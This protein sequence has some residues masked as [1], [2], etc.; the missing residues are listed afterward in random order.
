MSSRRKSKNQPHRVRCTCQS[1]ECYLGSYLDAYG[2]TQSGVEVWPETKK[3][4]AL[5]DEL[6]RLSINSVTN[7]IATLSTSQTPLLTTPYD[8]HQS[9]SSPSSYHGP[10]TFPSAASGTSSEDDIPCMPA[11]VQKPSSAERFCSRAISAREDGVRVFQCDHLHN[12]TLRKMSP[13]LLLIT[14]VVV[15]LT[16]YGHL[17][18]SS[19]SWLLDCLGMI[20][21]FVLNYGVNPLHG[22]V[23]LASSDA[24]ALRRI[25]KTITTAMKWLNI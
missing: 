24:F 25:P 3:A 1:H 12:F 15:I 4:H 7:P 8:R 17:S 13:V 22:H 5:A 16:V 19:A 23:G 18:T 6:K 14:L 20:I 10:R 21:E 9:P 2:N 11:P